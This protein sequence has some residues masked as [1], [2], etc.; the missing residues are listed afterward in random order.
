MKLF[1]KL[2]TSAVLLNLCAINGFSQKLT[3]DPA[4]TT[5][6]LPNGFTYYIRHNE[7]PKGKVFFYLVNNVGSNLE[8]DEQRG[9]AHFMEHMSFNGSVHFPG[10]E[11]VSFLEKAGVRFGA[12][13]NAYTSFDETVYQLPIAIDDPKMLDNGLMVMYDWTHNAL[14]DTKKIDRERGVVLEEKRMRSGG[15]QRVNDEF[16]PVLVNHS[17]YADRAPIGTEAVLKNFKPETLKSFYKDWYRPDLQALVVVGDV[18]P[19]IVEKKIRALFADLKNPVQEKVRPQFPIKLQGKNNFMALTDQ[20]IPG[21]TLQITIKRPHEKLLTVQDYGNYVNNNLFNQLLANRFMAVS[22]KNADLYLNAMANYG[23]F[24]GP[25]DAFSVNIATRPDGI[26]KG[27]KAVWTEIMKIKKSGFTP[28][29][30]E[31]AKTQYLTGAQAIFREKDKAQSSVYAQ[32]YARLFLDQE[33]SPGNEKETQLIESTLHTLTLGDVN[34]RAVKAVADTNRDVII[35]APAMYKNLLP[36]QQKMD[37]WFKQVDSS[38]PDQ[39]TLTPVTKAPLP[40][41]DQINAQTP[42]KAYI[43]SSTRIPEL[44]LTELKLSNG[45]KII[46]KPTT[47]AN[48]QIGIS[49]FS[50]GGTSV[51][52]DSQY[53]SAAIASQIIGGG[54]VG[55]YN[56]EQ[57]RQKLSGTMVNVVPFIDERMEGVHAGSSMKDLETALKYINLYFT[58][59]RKD[60][61]SFNAFVSHMK[62]ALSVPANSPEKAFEDTLS[63]VLSNYS[64]RRRPANLEDL[65]KMNLDSALAIYKDRFKDAAGF[66]FVFVGNFDVDTISPLLCH[67]L[68]TLPSV[69]GKEQDRNLHIHIPKGIVSKKINSGSTDK[70]TVALVINGDYTYNLRENIQLQAISSIVQNRI[71]ERL[72][73]QDG[74]VY[75]P[76][77]RLSLAKKPEG[78]YAFTIRFVCSPANADQLIK[79]TWDEIAKLKSNGPTQDDLS[80]F[81]AERNVMMKNAQESNGFWLSYLAIQYQDQ[82][83]PKA[84]LDYGKELDQLT[85][86]GLKTAMNQYLTDQNYVKL[87]MLP[88]KTK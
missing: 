35:T 88:E 75:S 44:Q 4:V 28:D 46:L 82:E 34:I 19:A 53:P 59:P 83:D 62:S 61:L 66:T 9:L 23:P 64:I 26:E 40:A 86:K 25:L 24:I 48:D 41:A 58:Q 1:R 52:S 31:N 7:N 33:A 49:A 77:A 63:S 84:I 47:L 60:S 39:T 20:E 16:F 10:D 68:G 80:K 43:V 36:D 14:L 54:G 2:F 81:K 11:M 30:F 17:R 21:T 18:D 57:L 3:L 5:G 8:T 76:S 79:D 38:I 50:M 55:E 78:T 72:R 27:F 15:A 74:E 13:L 69:D 65:K 32:E 51:Y 56:A 12:D 73:K 85:L 87:V 22:Q 37:S 42:E 71:L 67:Y 70:A 6:K 45:V 29:E